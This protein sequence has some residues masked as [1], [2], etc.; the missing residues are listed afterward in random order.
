MYFNKSSKWENGKILR[1]HLALRYSK[2]TK[3]EVF[4]FST[5]EEK[6]SREN[7][8]VNW[9]GTPCID[10][11]YEA[12]DEELQGGGGWESPIDYVHDEAYFENWSVIFKQK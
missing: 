4:L 3:N 12:N 11:G 7:E 6:D 1:D 9:K 5:I 10:Y 2:N 8:N